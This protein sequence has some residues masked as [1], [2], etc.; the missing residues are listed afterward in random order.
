LYKI[1]GGE[2]S[3]KEKKMAE[4]AGIQVFEYKL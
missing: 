3:D 1:G 2:Q 4:A